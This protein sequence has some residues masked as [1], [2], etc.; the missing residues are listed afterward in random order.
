MKPIT[1]IFIYEPVD[2]S[3]YR[4]LET[5]ELDL[6][7]ID[8]KSNIYYVYDAEGRALKLIA[9]K[10]RVRIELAEENP[11]HAR[12]LELAIRDFLKAIDDKMG[13]NQEAGLNELVEYCEKFAI[14]NYPPPTIKNFFKDLIN[15]INPFK[16]KK[17]RI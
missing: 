3:V 13:E 10:D 8:V 15:E 7:P 17:K 2:L 14:E 12:E 5:A 1:P 16:N 11:N 4:E 6:E 9:D